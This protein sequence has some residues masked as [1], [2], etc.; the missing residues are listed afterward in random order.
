MSSGTDIMQIAELKLNG[1]ASY[2][3]VVNPVFNNVTVSNT[4]VPVDDDDV[5]T[6]EGSYAPINVG[7]SGDNQLLYMGANNTLYYPSQAMT[8]GAQRAVFR[9][10]GIVA[11]TPQSGVRAI[12]LNFDDDGEATGIAPMDNGKWIMDNEAGAWYTLDGRRLNGK[13]TRKGLYINNHRIVNN[14]K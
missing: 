10:H 12:V 14:A 6:F 8:I 7:S 13:P 3:A 4:P 2:N 9:L 1:T 5:V 11:G